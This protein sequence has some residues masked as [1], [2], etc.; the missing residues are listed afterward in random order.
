MDRPT[1]DCNSR[2]YPE[3]QF[4]ELQFP[5]AWYHATPAYPVLFR[6]SLPLAWVNHSVA[7]L[8]DL[9]LLVWFI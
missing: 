2:P 6:C 7:V 4:P 9:A 3:L 5:E 1:H 8:C